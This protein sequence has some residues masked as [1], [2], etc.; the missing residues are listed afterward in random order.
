MEKVGVIICNYNKKDFVV[1]CIESLK[2]QTMNDFD[3]YVVDNASTD[4]SAA[5]LK[6]NFGE[7][8]LLICNTDNLGGSGGFN[9]GIEKAMKKKY[10]LLMLLDNDVILAADCIEQCVNIMNKHVDIGMLG[11]E[12]LKMDYPDRIQEFAPTLN[13]DAM[14]FELNHGGEVD[15]GQLPDME[16]CDYVPACAM[17][18]RN[19]V[20]EEIGLMPQENFI[21]YDDITWGVKCHRAGYRVVAT[22]LAKVWH[23][24][25]AAINPTTFS[26]YYLN[27]NKI[28]F[29]TRY[30]AT[31]FDD[32]STTDE[33]ITTRA[34]NII[35]D[36]F[37]G[38]YS[39]SKKGMPN[40]VKTRMEAFWDALS[41][42]TGKADSYKIRKKEPPINK[43]KNFILEKKNIL[44][45]MN[46]LWE[47]TRRIVNWLYEVE[48]KNNIKFNIFIADKDFVD[49]DLLGI[50]VQSESIVYS[51]S[52]KYD[53]DLN[54]CK[55]IYKLNVEKF[56]KLWIDGWLNTV[57]DEED[58]VSQKAYAPSYE[59]FKLCFED[60]VKNKIR[61]NL[62]I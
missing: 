6:E 53:A 8:I 21:Y 37:E 60:L 59:I 34:G 41:D 14:N 11:C 31:D 27:R 17:M 5:Y 32:S 38:I 2:K 58:Y 25:G 36:I 26:S 15:S 33:Q 62:G 49:F 4:G 3:I 12:I 57:L 35:S 43:L 47:D 45:H 39:C 55:H 7:D 51:T 9:S 56:D 19:T 1:R 22:S 23:K 29:F 28:K 52:L 16:D 40:M 13:Y 30:M 10:H 18:V 48:Q 50:K 61:E 54:M 42:V 46:G 24:G 44:I 20:I